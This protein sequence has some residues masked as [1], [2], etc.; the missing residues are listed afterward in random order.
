MAVS[1]EKANVR[2]GPSAKSELLWQVER[3]HP[4][5]VIERKDAWCFFKD[6]E[7]DKGWIHGSLLDQTAA[8]IVRAKLSNI[9]SGPG[10]DYNVVFTVDR[11]IPFKVLGKKGDWYR[12]RHAD[13]DEGWIHKSLVW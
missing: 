2:S 6:F 5:L 11:G 13:G 7:G 4:L 8:V 9:R 10:T 3:Y 1:V 12:I